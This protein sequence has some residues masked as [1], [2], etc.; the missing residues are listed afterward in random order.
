MILS[1][2][3]VLLAVILADP[4]L[5]QGSL[6]WFTLTE[7]MPAVARA[8]GAP[9][10]VAD[11][12]NGLQSWQYHL[13]AGDGHEP[14]HYLVFRRSDGRLLSVTRNFDP[15]R[16]FDEL[17][18]LA[19][20]TTRYLPGNASY[21]ARVRRLSGGRVLLAMGS[22]KKG[23]PIGQLVLLREEDLAAQYPW[24]ADREAEAR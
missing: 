11:F 9:K 10:Q 2:L 15:E 21:G 7:T 14:S 20:T 3:A 12:G 13:G 8:L 6:L 24:V 4:E 16:K 5:R 19:Q 23:Q 22:T 1:K 17:F 18:P